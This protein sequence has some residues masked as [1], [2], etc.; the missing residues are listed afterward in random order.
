VIILGEASLASSPRGGIAM[1]PNSSAE[2]AKRIEH[3]VVPEVETLISIQT[4]PNAVCFLRH[5]TEK[6]RRLQLDADDQGVVRF[7]VRAPNGS[8]PIEVHLDCLGEDG[9]K[10]HYVIAIRGDA[11]A[12]IKQGPLNPEQPEAAPGSHGTVRPPLSGDYLA[13]SNKELVARGYPPRPDPVT[14]P[15]RYARWRRKVATPFTLVKPRMT[16]HPGVSFSRPQLPPQ[17]FSPT[18]PLPPPVARSIFNQNWDTW[19]GAY[20]TKPTGQFFSIQADWKVPGVFPQSDSPPYSAVAE[21]IGLDSSSTD[22]YQSGSDSE[23]WVIS[24]F[25]STWTFTNYWMWIETL[26][27]D[28][29]GLPNFPVSP[30]DSVSVDIFVADE[31]GMTWFQNDNTNGGLTPADNSVWFMI[32]NYTKG[33]SFW[34][35]LPTAP[36]SID[37]K[38]STWFTGSTAEFIIER[39]TDLDNNV[40]YPLAPFGFTIMQG[41]YYGDSEYGDQ[42]WRLSA[43]G[44]TPWDCT[45]TYLNM[46]NSSDNNLLAVPFSVPD[47]IDPYDYEIL[48]L[49][50]N[51]S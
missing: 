2:K 49:W 10:T 45:L 25:G 26:P 36:Q 41:C 3:I 29:W 5:E 7:H 50:V 51:Y 13:L 40:P 33:L 21:W 4:A 38:Q 43:N 42:Q 9:K 20:L 47:P 34:G 8:K 30:G 19:S 23:C 28:P 15:A 11:N 12:D 44:S 14:A 35:T 24:I 39:P 31:N 18:L 1:A 37:G 6:D 17:L 27:F 46:V 16:P 22:L 32:Y 48:W